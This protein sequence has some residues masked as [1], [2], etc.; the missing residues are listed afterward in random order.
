M[1]SI[2]EKDLEEAPLRSNWCKYVR[3]RKIAYWGL[4]FYIILILFSFDKA[5]HAFFVLLI[6]SWGLI[7]IMVILISRS[8]LNR[9][10]KDLVLRVI[11]INKI[12][13]FSQITREIGI[14]PS[15]VELIVGDLITNG[16]LN[17][18]ISEGKFIPLT[19]NHI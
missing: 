16:K 3:Y 14:V 2:S 5:I 1:T 10:K 12:N 4:S 11:Q 17:G 19:D 7:P 15:C 6:W 13:Q 8:N 18:S 9:K